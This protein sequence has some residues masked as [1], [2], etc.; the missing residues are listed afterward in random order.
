[1]ARFNYPFDIRIGIHTGDVVA[2]VVG[3]TK[4][5]YDIWGE[6]VNI[7]ARMEQMCEPDRINISEATYAL[8]KSDF[9]CNYRGRFPAKH[10]GEMDMFYVEKAAVT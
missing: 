2:G 4:M 3:Q 10:V 5:A 8:V 1:M 6:T 7:A 9:K